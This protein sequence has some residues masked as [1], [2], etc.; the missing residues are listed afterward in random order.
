LENAGANYDSA[1]PWW[2]FERLQRLVARAPGSATEVRAA[3]A[4]LQDDFFV[5]TTAA[6]ARVAQC[7][8]ASD[9][10]AAIAT[11]RALVDSTTD[12]AISLVS[13]LTLEF[14]H[15]TKYDAAPD[16][17]AYWDERDATVAASN[18]VVAEAASALA[19]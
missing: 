4:A 10:P 5:E 11:L 2:K 17:A 9:G 14:L 13:Q 1:A 7:L 6:E 19:S 12:R 15:Q 8:A 16:L 18:L 3:F